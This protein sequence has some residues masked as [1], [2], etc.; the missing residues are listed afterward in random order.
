MNSADSKAIRDDDWIWIKVSELMPSLIFNFLWNRRIIWIRPWVS[1]GGRFF[2]G[3]SRICTTSQQPDESNI[4]FWFYILHTSPQ[5][6]LPTRGKTGWNGEK[7]EVI[8]PQNLSIPDFWF[9]FSQLLWGILKT[10][11]LNFILTSSILSSIVR[12]FRD[13]S[14]SIPHKYLR[15]MHSGVIGWTM[16]KRNKKK[17]KWQTANHSVPCTTLRHYIPLAFVYNTHQ[18]MCRCNY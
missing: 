15:G 1:R 14:Q 16:L 7:L 6:I 13:T 8:S 10:S 17:L 5:E 11:H 18:L 2:S 3:I 12:P 4:T 9:W